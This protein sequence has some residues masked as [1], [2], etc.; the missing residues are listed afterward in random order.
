MPAVMDAIRAS[1]SQAWGWTRPMTSGTSSRT[2][3]QLSPEAQACAGWFRQLGR[4]LKVFRLYKPDNPV[5]LQA[6]QAVTGSLQT[7]LREHQGWDLRFSA[8]AIFLSE[9]AVVRTG[10]RDAGE[11]TTSNAVDP[12][13]FLFY[14]DG[15]RRLSFQPDVSRAELDSLIE[16]IKSASR[17]PSTHD[18]LV[19]L[20]WQANLNAIRL[21]AVPLEQTIYLSSKAG[22]T[23]TGG[24][25]RGQ[26]Y[27]WSPSGSEIRADLGQ[28]PG[29]QGLHRDT[30]DDWVLPTESVDVAEAY[31]RLEPAM[32]PARERFLAD[33][34]KESAVAWTTQAKAL[35]QELV[36]LDP[37]SEMRSALARS[38]TTW[39]AAALQRAAW[40]EAEQAL[41][42]LRAI[43]P[44]RSLGGDELAAALEGLDTDRIAELLDESDV[45]PARFP[46]LMV[47]LGPGGLA[48]ACAIMSKATKARSRAAACTALCF[49]S[50][51]NPELLAPWLGDSRWHVVRNI[52]FVLGHIGGSE[53]VPLL[54][55]V[56]RHPEVRVRRQLVQ[57]LGGVPPADRVPLLIGQLDTRDPQLLASALNM[58]TREKNAQVARAIL[59]CIEAPDF[60]SRSEGNQRALFSALGDVADDEAVPALET[61]LH[62][63]GWF[64]RRSFERVAAARTLRHIGSDNAM[65]VLE[66]GLRSRH[67]AVRAASLDAIEMRGRS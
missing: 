12:L 19:T 66:A 5:V 65:A 53:V 14:R 38:A 52:V 35:L 59:G 6:Q 33:W 24:E 55:A 44:D 21:E 27:A 18:D 29:S 64:A 23:G 48:L 42:Q 3:P 17:G 31:A 67:E 10:Q 54:R 58:L 37:S 34:Q 57:S 15:V 51:D 43:D 30:F 7:L 28:L 41:D 4:A 2:S 25:T 1:G 13:P 16:G 62:K 56:S 26:G 46:A 49:M 50:A 63:G 22:G 45:D 11:A 60:E 47:G 40:D 8:S 20:L 39:I 61:M 32:A 36:Q 9:E